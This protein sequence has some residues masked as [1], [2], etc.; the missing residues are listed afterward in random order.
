MPS[1]TNKDVF[2]VSS[3]SVILCEC[4]WNL[5]CIFV[6][7]F[8][9]AKI[10]TLTNY[11]L[12]NI[13]LFYAVQ[14]GVVLITSFVFNYF[15][16]K[17]KLNYFVTIGAI[18][19]ICLVSLV[20]F[21][22]DQALIQYLPLLA[23]CYGFGSS[24][25]WIGQNNL[26]TIA[27]S[28]RYQ[29][30][31]FSTKKTSVIFVKALVPIILGS[32]ISVAGF[33]IVAIM[34]MVCTIL[35]FICSLLV[36]ANGKFDMN[37]KFKPFLNKILK[38][39]E[40]TK[41]LRKTYVV[42]FCTGL[43]I[44][45]LAVLFTYMAYNNMQ[46][47]FGLGVVKTVI[48]GLSLISLFIFMKYYRKRHAKEYCFPAMILVPIAGIVMLAW[49]NIYTILVFFA[50]YN[51][52]GVDLTSLTDMRRAGSIR[53]LNMHD[54]VLEHNALFEVILSFSRILSF[55]LLAIT[56]LIDTQAMFIVAFAIAIIG[57]VCFGWATYSTERNLV[58]QDQQWK[59]QHVIYN[60]KNA[61]H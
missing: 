51:V 3:V 52:L 48:T 35:L 54:Q 46:S 2:T 38:E 1:Y 32:F 44:T 33:G 50:V 36:K 30:R 34:M 56:G 55:S 45:P 4:F 13:S 59:K 23:V 25:F 18:I 47:D 40:E 41:M 11:S 61:H 27:V 49:M 6:D 42:A 14:Y 31:F 19:M 43:S 20:Y 29:V 5:V 15:L 26:A 10:L 24:S 22:S 28:S 60:D 58:E 7:T 16:K 39:K 21:L 53:M 8:L 57:F 17:I 37:F 9:I 12:Y